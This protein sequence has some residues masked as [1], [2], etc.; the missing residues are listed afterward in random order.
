MFWYTDS[1][2]TCA[3]AISDVPL[4]PEQ[5]IFHCNVEVISIAVLGIIVGESDG[6]L[7]GLLAGWFEGVEIL[8]LIDG[9]KVGDGDTGCAV[10]GGP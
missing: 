9:V 7:T 6:S 2:I 10:T 3:T 5:V 1:S 4:K 8:G